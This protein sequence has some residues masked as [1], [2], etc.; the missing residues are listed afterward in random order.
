MNIRHAALTGTLTAAVIMFSSLTFAAG[1]QVT[2]SCTDGKNLATISFA[3]QILDDVC[4]DRSTEKPEISFAINNALDFWSP[5]PLIAMCAKPLSKSMLQFRKSID[6][7][8]YMEIAHD[9]SKITASIRLK[10]KR[11]NMDCK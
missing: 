5:A 11:Y 1:P 2:F 8:I 3:E 10:D 6:E 7:Q 4:N 9:F